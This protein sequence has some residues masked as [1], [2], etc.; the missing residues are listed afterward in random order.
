[1]VLVARSPRED[2]GVA[3]L[4]DAAPNPYAY[5]VHEGKT[6]VIKDK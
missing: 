3:S 6:I 5:F 2:A 1:M 4:S